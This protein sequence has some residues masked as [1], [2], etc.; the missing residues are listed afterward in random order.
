MGNPSFRF[1]DNL[2]ECHALI[3]QLLFSIEEQDRKYDALQRRFDLL[4]AKYDA[5]EKTHEAL[6]REHAELLQHVFPHH[7][8]RY[9]EHPEQPQ[10]NVN[11]DAAVEGQPAETPPPAEEPETQTVGPYTRR[12]TSR[13]PREEKLPKD[14]PRE[15]VD[16]PVP[17]EIRICP[18]HGERTPIGHDEVEKLMYTPPKLWVLVTRYFKY[19]CANHAECGVGSPDRPIGLVEG[20][21]YDTSVATEILVGKYGYHLPIYRLEDYFASSGWTP[22]RSTLL[23]ILASAA[24]LLPPLINVSAHHGHMVFGLAVVIRRFR[25]AAR[26]RCLRSARSR[27][28]VTRYSRM[29]SGWVCRQMSGRSAA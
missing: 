10:C 6:K 14:L 25:R 5:L 16:A 28:S 19:A 20:D 17:D 13:K 29:A 22:G 2:P 8:E 26:R 9:V 1:P 15:Y 7:S 18:I 27:R 24:R 3:E 23:N 21:R 12:K 11:E 4:Q